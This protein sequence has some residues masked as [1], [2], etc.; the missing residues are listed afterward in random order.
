M[1]K[2]KSEARKAKAKRIALRFASRCNR[3]LM[4]PKDL[5]Y[6]RIYYIIGKYIIEKKGKVMSEFQY[7]SIKKMEPKPG[8]KYATNYYKQTQSEYALLRHHVTHVATEIMRV[9]DYDV[10]LDAWIHTPLSKFPKTKGRYSLIEILTD[11]I[12]QIAKNKDVPSGILGRWNRLFADT[13]WDIVMVSGV[14]SRYN[15]Q[16]KELFD[17]QPKRT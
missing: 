9:C 5:L 17:A 16:F 3:L 10:V 14:P 4:L 13:E 7:T 12:D 8:V 2:P 6:L 1:G 11:M 15:T